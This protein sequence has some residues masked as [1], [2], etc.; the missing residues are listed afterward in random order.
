MK[1][2]IVLL[3]FVLFTG[4]ALAQ[5]INQSNV[6]AVV[7][8]AFQLKFPGAEDVK[9]K[10]EKGNY[11]LKYEVNNK[12]NKLTIDNKGKVLKHSQDLYVSEVPEAVLKTIRA[13]VAYFDMN[14]ADRIEEGSK[15]TYEIN[16]KVDGKS[17]FFWINSKGKLLKYRKELKKSEVPSQF[18]SLINDQYGSFDYNRSK[19]V[20]ESGRKIYIIRGEIDDMNHIFSIDHKATV[21]RHEQD[22]KNSRIPVPIL[23]TI[24][25]VYNGYE[26]RDADL[27]EE[28]G[29]T[30]YIL[31]LRKS[32][33][34]IYVYF[35]IDGK[36]LESK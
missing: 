7:L 20:E 1:R 12:D 9:W 35:N 32:K 13:K 5:N 11:E 23:N 30:I 33:E 29:K 25:S 15:I 22:L 27:R 8:N 18:L 6:P 31:R 28:G 16:F 26:I 2:I 21:V 4:Y 3:A 19:Y 34:N 17:H 24:R 10:L 36:I 14:D